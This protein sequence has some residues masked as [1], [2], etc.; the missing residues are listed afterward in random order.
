MND[1]IYDGVAKGT[2]NLQSMLRIKKKTSFG[3]LHLEPSDLKL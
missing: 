3:T 2:I 1:Q